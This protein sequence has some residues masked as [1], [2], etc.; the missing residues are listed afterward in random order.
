MGQDGQQILVKHGSYYVRVHP[1]RIKLV[2]SDTE[3]SRI[4]LS[5]NG[6]AEN[7][8][9]AHLETEATND[10]TDKHESTVQ[11]IEESDDDIQT[12]KRFLG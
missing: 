4:T 11:E 7:K 1:C 10:I 6:I 2:H 8:T 3:L 9:S 5:K 12:R